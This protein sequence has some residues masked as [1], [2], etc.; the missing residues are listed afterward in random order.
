M[1]VTKILIADASPPDLAF[2]QELL[3]KADYT[4]LAA[5]S[6]AE[7]VAKAIADVPDLIF[8]NIDMPD[9]D[10]YAA[11]RAIQE[12][13]SSKNIPVIFVSS[14]TE[15]ADRGRAEMQGAKGWI[16]KPYSVLE[17]A[18]QLIAFA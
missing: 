1:T 16:T 15:K 6:G 4:V 12:N 3:S 2:I 18:E 13:E 9:V 17:I 7:A 10:G 8:L 5:T 11:F 14:E